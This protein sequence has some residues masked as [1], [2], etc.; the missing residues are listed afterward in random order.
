M[1]NK[2]TLFICRHAKSSWKDLNLSDKERPLNKRGKRDAP[3]MGK[4]L[5]EKGERADLIISSNAVRAVLTAKAY[6][7]EL[8]YP[9]EN[10]RIVPN[11]YEAGSRELFGVIKQIDDQY[12]NVFMFGHNPGFTLLYNFITDERLDNIPTSGV[13][14]VSFDVSSWKEI[15]VGAGLTDY[16]EYPKKYRNG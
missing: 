11:I 7:K 8:G 13:V 16:F 3:F 15:E 5:S 10:I 14:K 6:A 1:N 2:K 9:S 12:N 4:L